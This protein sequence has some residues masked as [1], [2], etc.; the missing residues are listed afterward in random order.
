MG[1]DLVLSPDGFDFSNRTTNLFDHGQQAFGYAGDLIGHQCAVPL[2][3]DD[4]TM[5]Y[6]FNTTTS[7]SLAYDAITLCGLSGAGIGPKPDRA[8][9]G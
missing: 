8:N 2:G 3:A 4:D 9:T 5:F 1:D 6:P 7:R